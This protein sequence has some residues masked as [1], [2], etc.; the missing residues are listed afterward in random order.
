MVNVFDVVGDPGLAFGAAGESS[1]H[2]THP[3]TA[4]VHNM[5]QAPLDK[6]DPGVRKIG[7]KNPD[8]VHAKPI[9]NDTG[10]HRSEID[11]KR[12]VPTVVLKGRVVGCVGKRCCRPIQTARQTLPP[13]AIMRPAAPWSV[14]WLPFS[15]TRR[16]NSENCKTSVSSRRP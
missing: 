14:P 3:A 9:V 12:H 16:P 10:V 6:V 8:R 4:T 5:T 13:M 2:D 1:P 15:S 7:A 11:T